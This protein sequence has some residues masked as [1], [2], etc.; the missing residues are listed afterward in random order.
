MAHTNTNTATTAAAALDLVRR[1][2]VRN[3]GLDM[4]GEVYE[5]RDG[6]HGADFRCFDLFTER[7]A[8]DDWAEFTGLDK[9]VEIATTALQGSGWKVARVSASEKRWFDVVITRS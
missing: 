2:L 4:A 3:V 5:C 9:A 8:D 6:N 1:A 7:Y